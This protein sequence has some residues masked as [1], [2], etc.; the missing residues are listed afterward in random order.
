MYASFKIDLRRKEWGKEK[1]KR[2]SEV[3][4]VFSCG[5]YGLTKFDRE[6]GSDLKPGLFPFERGLAYCV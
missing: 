5:F 3:Y 6:M 1:R 2:K 4:S